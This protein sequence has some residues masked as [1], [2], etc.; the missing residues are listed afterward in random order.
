VL[1]RFNWSAMVIDEGHRLK[2][3]WVGEMGGLDSAR[4]RVG[5][6]GIGESCWGLEN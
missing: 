3:G 6:M 2:C 1:R 5:G 4:G